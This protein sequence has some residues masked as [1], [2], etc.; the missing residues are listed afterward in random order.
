MDDI[1]ASVDNV[2][3]KSMRMDG[4]AWKMLIFAAAG[5]L[6]YNILYHKLL[7]MLAVSL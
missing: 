6:S 4:M 7:L 3:S 5:S 2:S 1:F